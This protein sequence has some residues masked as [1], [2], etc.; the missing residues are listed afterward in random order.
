M[1]QNTQKWRHSEHTRISRTDNNRRIVK[2]CILQSI[3]K[4]IL[5]QYKSVRII[6]QMEL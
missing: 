2:D 6:K 3:T 5:L 4:Y 1:N